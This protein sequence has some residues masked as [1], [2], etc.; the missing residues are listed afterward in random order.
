MLKHGI[1]DVTNLN[2]KFIIIQQVNCQGR[3]GAGI[4]L[5][6][7]KK[8]S[9]VY[10]DYLQYCDSHS[11]KASRLGHIQTSTVGKDQYICNVFGQYMYGRRG[12]YTNEQALLKGLKP[13]F[14][15]ASRADL[16]VFIPSHIGS[17]L[18]GGDADV[19]QNG[20]KSLE[21]QYGTKVCL[22]DYS[23]TCDNLNN[24]FENDGNSL[25]EGAEKSVDT[26]LQDS[27]QG[28][29]VQ[30]APENPSVDEPYFN[31]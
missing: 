1:G 9:K 17:G 23:K 11:N 3:M 12:H 4:A 26:S 21:Q 31:K 2:G 14:A 25:Q 20:I 8:W 28:A 7:R 22:V 6:I 27:Y 16:P 10:T 29:N 18:A 13:I 15:H 24:V 5:A 19:I 30:H